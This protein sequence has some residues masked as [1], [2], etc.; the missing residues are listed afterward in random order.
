MSIFGSNFG[1]NTSVETLIESLE[2][3]TADLLDFINAD[4]NA[5]QKELDELQT[6]KGKLEEIEKDENELYKE[7]LSDTDLSK[8]KKRLEVVGDLL[9]QAQEEQYEHQENNPEENRELAQVLREVQE[10]RQL[11]QN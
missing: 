10:L 9:K 2:D 4:I 1:S 7:D 8:L 11:Y 3:D 6:I 5:V